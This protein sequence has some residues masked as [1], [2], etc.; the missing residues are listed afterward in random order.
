MKEFLGVGVAVVTPFKENKEVD[1]AALEN[2]V[3]FLIKNGI[4]YLVALGTTAETATLTKEEQNRVARCILEKTAAR[5]P[6]MIGAGGNDTRALIEKLQ[7]NAIYENFDGLLIATPYYNKPNQRG[8]YEHYSTIAKVSSKP[9]VLY[10]VPS[11]TGV[12]MS[13]ETTLALAKEFENIVGVKEASG[14]LEQIS[15][16]ICEKPEGFAV[17]SGDDGLTLPMLSMGA[18]GVIS[19]LA[20]ALP[21]QMV[22]MVHSA[23]SFKYQKAQK[24]HQQLFPLSQEIFKEG[25]PTGIKALMATKGLLQNYLRLPLVSASKELSESLQQLSES[26]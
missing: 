18:V 25:N 20:N 23:L 10:N 19:V 3:D 7:T 15:R 17:I 13:V 6:L 8:L 5:V 4:D 2:L 9:I 11:R 12:N 26:F 1:F 14:D 21:K 24:L 16:I 22:E